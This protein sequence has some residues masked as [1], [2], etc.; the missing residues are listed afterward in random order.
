M[1]S[2]KPIVIESLTE[3]RNFINKKENRLCDHTLGALYMWRDFY[4]SKYTILNDMLY[5]KVEFS[6]DQTYFTLPMG[7]GK[8]EEAL[9]VLKDYTKQNNTQLRFCIIPEESIELLEKHFKDLEYNSNRDWSDYL[10]LAEDLRELKGRKYSGQRNHMNKF[11]RIYPN[12][13][14]IEMNQ[15]NIDKVLAFYETY[16]ANNVKAMETAIEENYKTKELIKNLKELELFGGFI[17]V[18]GQIIAISLGEIIKDTLYVHIEKALKEY[19][20]SYQMIMNEFA[21][22]NANGSILY[23]NREE[24]TGDLGLRTSKLS[25]HPF[26]LLDKYNVT[27]NE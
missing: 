26:N 17:E 9:D 19:P 13:E 2:F 22:H 27:V 10:Y 23:I 14:Y 16:E 8:M 15:D 1:L 21:K 11:K 18:D 3:I 20:G 4:S 24:D 5:M 12:Y 6:N 7:T 25:Y